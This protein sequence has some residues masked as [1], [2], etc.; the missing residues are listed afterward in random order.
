MVFLP[1]QR[2]KSVLVYFEKLQEEASKKKGGAVT[3]GLDMRSVA[4]G[5]VHA[6]QQQRHGRAPLCVASGPVYVYVVIAKTPVAT[7]EIQGA[8]Q[9]KAKGQSQAGGPA[10][11]P[12]RFPTP[13]VRP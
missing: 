13:S 2:L 6:V 8:S 4:T 12:V 9:H 5:A 1:I 10:F 7:T 11:R 3:V